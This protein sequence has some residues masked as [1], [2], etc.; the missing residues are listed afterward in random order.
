MEYWRPRG[1]IPGKPQR[2]VKTKATKRSALKMIPMTCLTIVIFGGIFKNSEAQ[3]V[4]EPGPASGI[5]V[6]EAPGFIMSDRRMIFQN[7]Y[8]PLDP[9]ILIEKHLNN[10]GIKIEQT[11]EW[12]E[13]RKE[14]AK[15][16]IRDILM[17]LEKTFVNSADIKKKRGKRGAVM[18]AI[19]MVMSIIGAII[20][21]TISTANSISVGTLSTKA[22]QL[23]IDLEIIQKTLDGIRGGLDEQVRFINETAIILNE[24]ADVMQRATKIILKHDRTLN[25]ILNIMSPVD[26]LLTNYMREVQTAVSQL[27][28]GHIPLYFVSQDI[29]RQMIERLTRREIDLIRIRIAFEMGNAM[30][31]YVDLERLEIGF[32][33][34]IPFVAPELIYQ[35]KWVHNVGFWQEDKFIKIKTPEV[36]AFQS[37]E[38]EVYLI[39]NLE[40]CVTFKEQNYMCPGKPFVPDATDA[41][42]GLKSDPSISEG[43]E[44]IISNMGSE[45]M[46]QAK[47]VRGKWLVSTCLKNMTVVHLN[48][49]TYVVKQVKYN[50]FYLQVPKDAIVSIGGLTLFHVT[51]DVWES[52][53]ENI[54][55]FQRDTFPIDPDVEYLLNHKERHVMK[56]NL[57]KNNITISNLGIIEVERFNWGTWGERSIV[58]LAILVLIM[59]GWLIV[60]SVKMKM[61]LILLT[62]SGRERYPNT[63]AF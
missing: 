51:N 28:Q 20:G 46:A 31:L 3:V 29:I 39:P 63:H 40:T 48:H 6:E 22:Q 26:R 58:G 57:R 2:G 12:L 50:V 38:P 33:L 21:T 24:Q 4:I 7:I 59:G 11:K 47:M 34:C 5:A 14:D 30:P 43:C 49:G 60:L 17:Q 52:Q 18:L 32:L 53:V 45:E 44:V 55:F 56:M 23:S 27:I 15:Q 10:A 16:S 41:I 54:D 1:R 25:E 36:V 13:I 9:E 61:L 19:S 8:I 35:T 42:C 62:T 37:W